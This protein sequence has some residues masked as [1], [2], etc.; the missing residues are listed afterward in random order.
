[1]S[2]QLALEMSQIQEQA[3][4][5]ALAMLNGLKCK[6]AIIDPLGIK[7]GDL[8]IKVQ[9]VVKKEKK[10]HH[11]DRSKYCRTFLEGM[12]VGD[13]AVIPVG[14]FDVISIQAASISCSN[15]LWGSGSVTTTINREKQIAEVLRIA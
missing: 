12:A 15:R 13:V 3:L 9:E 14:K 10:Y 8:E 5:R 2:K 4:K 7:H 1:M 11:G 6:Y